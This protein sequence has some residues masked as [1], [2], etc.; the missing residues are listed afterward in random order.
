MTAEVVPV[1]V[2][3]RRMTIR[4]RAAA[5]VMCFIHGTEPYRPGDTFPVR[6][7]HRTG[8]QHTILMRIV[9]CTVG[10]GGTYADITVEAT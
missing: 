8:V 6:L 3:D 5:P 7:P 10:P 4:V 1:P 9:G 2:A